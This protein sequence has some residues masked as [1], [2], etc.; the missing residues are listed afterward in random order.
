MP[1]KSENSRS[2]ALLAF[3]KVNPFPKLLSA[4]NS[5]NLECHSFYLCLDKFNFFCTFFP[6]LFTFLYSY[7]MLLIWARLIL[8]LFASA[9]LFLCLYS[10]FMITSTFTCTGINSIRARYF[11][12]QFL[13]TPKGRA[14][15]S[16]SSASCSFLHVQLKTQDARAWLHLTYS[17]PLTQ[18]S[19][20]VDFC[21][22]CCPPLQTY[23][24]PSLLYQSFLR[25]VLAFD[26]SLDN[27]SFS[28]LMMV[29]ISS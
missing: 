29:W 12:L 5:K 15:I 14:G 23:P 17:L 16:C 13:A 20:S 11:E 7:I 2:K 22:C 1:F 25:W 24:H 28:Y 4:N 9:S 19:S 26:D 27:K 10:Q 8:F 3:T 6:V 18:Q 21:H